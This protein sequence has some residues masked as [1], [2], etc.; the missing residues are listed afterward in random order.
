MK[1]LILLLL[2]PLIITSCNKK[3]D[4][5]IYSTPQKIVVAGKVNN[6][7]DSLTRI[8]FLIHRLGF[9]QE[10]LET[11]LDSAGNFAT[12]FTSYVPVDFYVS[13][14]NLVSMIAFPGDSIYFEFDGSKK[15]IEEILSTTIY[16]SNSVKINTDIA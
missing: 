8:T 6:A 2:I 16:S 5:S 14:R 9:G 13:Y 12:Y 1:H 4:E 3:N 7:S 15:E 10:E 11:D